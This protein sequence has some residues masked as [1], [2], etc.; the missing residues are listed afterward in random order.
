MKQTLKLIFILFLNHA[1]FAQTDTIDWVSDLEYIKNELP[2]K[3]YNLFFQL[4]E[5]EFN[6]QVDRLIDSVPNLTTYEILDNLNHIIAQIGDS[7]T[8]INY[9]Y[10]NKADRILPFSLY[11]F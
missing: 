4:S 10:L 2:K 6:K 5:I 1:I 3:H 7:H 11:W 9:G 8:S